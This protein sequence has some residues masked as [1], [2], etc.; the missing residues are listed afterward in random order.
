MRITPAQF[1]GLDK[2]KYSSV[3]KSILSRRV[4]TPWW[5]WLIT[6]FPYTL[7]PN[8]ITFLG[9]CFVFGNVLTLAYFDIEYEGKDLPQWVYAS[10]AFG[11]F[12]Y[13]SMDAIDGKQAR[14]LN[15]GS[16]L[17]EMFDH[18]CDA[19]NTSL[20]VVLAC[21]ALGLNRS[22]WTVASEVASL[23]NFYA[24]T[25]EE[26]HTGTLYLSAFSG[27]VEGI[28]M[29]I[30]IYIITAVHP[31]HQHFWQQPLV[32]RLRSTRRSTSPDKY[33]LASLPIN[34]AFMIFGAFG[35]AG[36]ML[37]AYYNV[38]AARHRDKKPIVTPL[39]GLLPFGAHTLILC[40]WLHAERVDGV[41]IVHDA[42]LLPFLGSHSSS[43]RML[44]SRPS[45]YWNGM[46]VYS[47]ASAID[48]NAQWLFGVEPLVQSSPT[49]SNVF[50]WM[51]FFVALFNY[52]RFAREIIWQICDYTGMACFTVRRRDKSGRWIE[53]AEMIH[54]IEELRKT[55]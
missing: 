47:L 45:P 20:E 23:L 46:M 31:L 25:W 17:G 12:A 52:V 38:I 33:S 29:I 40:A 11:L 27:P 18:G 50:I 30:V 54:Q 3:D 24:S 15:M 9:L 22:W 43:S 34:V 4:L 10:W 55:Q 28:V 8:A 1:E 13:Q 35:T 6:L 2:Y 51:S 44:P 7:G 32:P 26:Y 41:S 36:N 48:A 14:R 19:I 21:H 53:A 5:N 16:A 42:R 39:L 37:N 49:A